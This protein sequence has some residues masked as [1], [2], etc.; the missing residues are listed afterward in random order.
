MGWRFRKAMHTAKKKFSKTSLLFA[1]CLT[2]HL[3]RYEANL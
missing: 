2:L 3:E 1:E